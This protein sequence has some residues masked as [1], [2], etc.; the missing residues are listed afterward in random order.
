MKSVRWALAVGVVAALSSPDAKA[1]EPNLRDI[2]FLSCVEVNAMPSEQ[3]KA[4][5]LQIAQ[6]AADFY[7][8]RMPDN[9]QTGQQIG[10]LVRTGCTIAPEAYFSTVVAR[11][12]RVMGGGVEPPLSQPIDMKQAI[13]LTCKGVDALAPEK[14]KEIGTYIGREAAAHYRLTPGPEWTPDYIAALVYNG[15]KMYPDAYYLGM[16]GRAVRAVSAAR[17]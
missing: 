13:F 11:A 10:W 4:L 9:E 16:I 6:A 5:G 2:A 7:Q 3:R 12:V 15:C 17:G 8:T 1:A 14:S